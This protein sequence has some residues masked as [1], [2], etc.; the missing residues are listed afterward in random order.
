MRTWRV[1]EVSSGMVRN[2]GDLQRS[3]VFEKR[4]RDA[5]PI[6]ECEGA[7]KGPP[8]RLKNTGWFW[9]AVS[10]IASRSELIDSWV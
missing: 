2:G 10:M 5:Q 9:Q 3:P 1:C 7:R 6:Q 8:P 4:P